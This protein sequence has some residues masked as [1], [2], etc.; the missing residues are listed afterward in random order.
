[1]SCGNSFFLLIGAS[2]DSGDIYIISLGSLNFQLLELL[3]SGYVIDNYISVF[4]K[5]Q[6]ELIYRIYVTD[7]LKVLSENTAIHEGS[8]VLTERYID[9]IYNDSSHEEKE[10]RT[11]EE[12]I[13]TLME[14][15]RKV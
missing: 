2:P 6:K 7:S 5:E 3:G 14:K 11:E 15:L 4:H 8:K 9:L 12:V 10:E 13:S 1:M